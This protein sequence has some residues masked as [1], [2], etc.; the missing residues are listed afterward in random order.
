MT[1]RNPS[2]SEEF[3]RPFFFS[4]FSF[5]LHSVLLPLLIKV[6]ISV[7][8]L[9]LRLITLTKTF[10]ISRKL[11]SIIVSLYIA[12]KSFEEDNFHSSANEI[13]L[14]LRLLAACL[15]S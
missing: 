11:N 10:S 3:A 15:F 6:L 4:R 5:G 9:S 1:A 14:V 13:N 2:R 8:S 7:I 12:A